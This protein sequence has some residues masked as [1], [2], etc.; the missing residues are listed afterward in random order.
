M[1]FPDPIVRQMILCEYATNEGEPPKHTLHGVTQT[2]SLPHDSVFPVPVPELF[3][4]I[5]MSEGRGAGEVRIGIVSEESRKLELTTQAFPIVFRG[6]PLTR[7]ALVFE[8]TGGEFPAPGLYWVGL[9]Y[10]GKILHE[11][12]LEVLLDELP[13]STP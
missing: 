7:R 10:N 13:E 11:I 6:N 2:V 1:S 3:V 4:F 12:P 5:L 8:L 9:W